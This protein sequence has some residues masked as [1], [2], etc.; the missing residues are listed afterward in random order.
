MLVAKDVH[1][2]DLSKREDDEDDERHDQDG[3]KGLRE[4]QEESRHEGSQDRDED[5]E[6]DVDDRRQGELSQIAVT[7]LRD[8]MLNW[9]GANPESS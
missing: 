3:E 8:S 2:D 6:Q 1:G 7:C 9:H 4:Q 5:C